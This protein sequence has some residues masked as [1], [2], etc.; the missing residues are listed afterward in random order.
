MKVKIPKIL[1]RVI[2][3]SF[4]TVSIIYAT[5]LVTLNNTY[6]EITYK[7][8]STT[9]LQEEVETL[10]QSGDL[11]FPIGRELLKRWTKNDGSI[12]N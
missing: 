7:D 9:E 3:L 6:P 10:S 2:A 1:G 5:R 4:I 12:A 11:P 8:M